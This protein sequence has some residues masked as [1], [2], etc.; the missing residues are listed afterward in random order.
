MK[1]V[2]TYGTYDHL[3][4]GHIRLLERAK[5][6]GDYLIVG[7]TSEDF[8]KKRGK[9]NVQQTLMERVKAVKDTG[10]AD[11][12]VIEE[13]EGQ[14]IED[15]CKYGID[16]FTV[17]SDWVGKFDYLKEYCEVVYLER[18]EGISST[19]IRTKNINLKLGLVGDSINLEKIAKECELVNGIEINAIY[20]DSNISNFEIL[21]KINLKTN[22]YKEL[23]NNV[24]AVYI[25]SNPQFH[26]EQ[27]KEALLNKKHVL[28]E[29]PISLKEIECKELFSLAKENNCLLIESIKTKYSTA[30]KRLLLLLKTGII[31]DIVS[32]DA[33]C[34]SLKERN[35]INATSNWNTINSWGPTA[36]LPIFQFLGTNYIQKN[37][38]SLCKPENNNFDLFTKI[39]FIYDNSVASI[40]VGKGVKSEGELIIT[41]TKGYV[42]VPAPWWKMDYFELRYEDQN[43][44][45]RYFYQLEGEGI[46]NTILEF[47]NATKRDN[48]INGDE[49]VSIAIAK[50][51]EDFEKDKIIL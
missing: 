32:V 34:T 14:K 23:L 49:Q 50:I 25:Y 12:I 20:T 24:D 21:N 4:F 48:V 5:K 9:I 6:L 2:I 46:R 3:H 43:D 33:T 27:I 26:Y 40:K 30:Y 13:Y 39:D 37:I 22:D 19:E 17:G 29:A 44:N 45:K 7:V 47:V 41:G 15:I 36:L 51:M 8:D 10:L 38:I 42:Y 1:K 35:Y 28:C 31:G 18:T 16:I 11:E